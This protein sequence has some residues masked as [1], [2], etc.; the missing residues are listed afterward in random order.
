VQEY[1]PPKT[2]PENVAQE[3]LAQALLHIPHILNVDRKRIVLKVRKKQEGKAQYQKVDAKQ[4]RIEVY[5]NQAKFL[6]NPTDYLD[7]GL[8]LDHR[9]TRQ[10]FA[11][12]CRNKHV[13]NLFC[14]TGSVSV[15]AAK[16]GA[17]SVTSVDM[18]NTYI[19]WAKDNFALNN[20]QGAYEFVQ[21]DCLVWIARQNT[22][23]KFDIMFIDPPSFSNSKRM[24]NDWDV[25][26]DHVAL[27]TNAKELLADE[28]KIYFSNNLRS[29]KID[30]AS[31]EALGFSV[32]NITS[33]TIDED[34]K[35]NQ[36]IHHCWILSV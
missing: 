6:I 33:H 7:V 17:K 8:F 27:L 9:L 29:F 1:A 16:Q 13:L 30:T 5:E 23:Q 21:A 15:H 26:R 22:A 32:N 4:S 18:S 11:A 10:H 14:Y 31:I 35:R 3:R 19:Q 2:I 28:G 25:Q 24:D 36:K 34:F 20:L 12:Q